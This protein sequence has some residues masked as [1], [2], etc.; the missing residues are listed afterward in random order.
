MSRRERN[1]MKRILLFI[2][3]MLIISASVWIIFGIVQVREQEKTL[4]DELQRKAKAVTESIEIG[5]RYILESNDLRAAARLVDS[6]Q[7][8]ERTQGCRLYKADG[9]LLAV[10]ERIFDWKL[11]DKE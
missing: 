3:P 1:N 10:T 8:R 11:R 6:F 7:K 9:D 5:A 2:L 4:M